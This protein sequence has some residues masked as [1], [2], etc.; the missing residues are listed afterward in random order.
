[1]KKLVDKYFGGIPKTKLRKVVRKKEVIQKR[2]RIAIEKTSF[3]Q[4]QLYLSWPGV[5]AKAKDAIYLDI[6]CLCLGQGES[7]RLVKKMRNEMGIVQGVGA[8][9]YSP[10]DP[11]LIAVTASIEHENL[12]AT[13]DQILIELKDKQRKKMSLIKNLPNWKCRPYKLNSIR[14]L[15]LMRLIPFKITFY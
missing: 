8:S 14:T 4:N 7:S 9:S 15:S 13:L 1:M 10:K 3:K 11:G 2:P 6:F 12:Q 5:K